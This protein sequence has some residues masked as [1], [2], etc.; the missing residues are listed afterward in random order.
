VRLRHSFGRQMMLMHLNI[1][2][3]TLITIITVTTVYRYTGY[4]PNSVANTGADGGSSGV[5]GTEVRRGVQQ[6]SAVRGSR[7][8]SPAEPG[9]LLQLYHMDVYS[10]R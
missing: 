7:A 1:Y 3:C 10:E 4:V 8:K 2:F 5:M 9:D 6:L